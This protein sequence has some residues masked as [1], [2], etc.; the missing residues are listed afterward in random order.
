[1]PWWD[2][3]ASGGA[4][5][6]WLGTALAKRD[7]I[8]MG[9]GVTAPIL[10]YHPAIVAQIFATLAYMFLNRVFLGI[11]KGEALNEIPSGNNW[12]SGIE[13]FERMK[14]AIYIIKK[15]W[16]EE[17]V[18]FTGSY[19]WVKDSKLYL[20]LESQLLFISQH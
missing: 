19:Y 18:N 9:T 17:W 16:R 3:G 8:M 11:G 2:S 14:E 6:P 1:M 13:R 15:L 12:Q 5:W 7:K 4:A 10:R 20:N